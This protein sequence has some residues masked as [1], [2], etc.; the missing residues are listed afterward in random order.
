MKI[1]HRKIK[2]WVVAATMLLA[3]PLMASAEDLAVG[4]TSFSIGPRAAYSNPK[5]AESG[6]WSVGAQARVHLTPVLG[7]E[8]SI[9]Y[10]MNNYADGVSIK[11]YPVQ[12]SLLA[13]LM[14]HARVSPF[15]LGG[16]GW[17]FTRVE[18]PNM[19]KT[20]DNR[21][22]V[23]AG[24]GVEVRLNRSLSIDGAYRYIWLEDVTVSEKNVL[25]KTYK[26]SGPMVTLALNFL[27]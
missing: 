18:G 16:A 14:P 25:E 26:D 15:L 2:E 7:L 20:T 10:R 6:K 24:G 11:S 22:G 17:H 5:D 9:D 19:E 12:A 23:H 4:D 27:F 21:F 8:G 13:Y 3:F 1:N